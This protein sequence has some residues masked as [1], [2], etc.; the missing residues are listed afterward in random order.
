[1]QEQPAFLLVTDLASVSKE[2]ILDSELGLI[3][4]VMQA[5][6]MYSLSVRL[7]IAFMAELRIQQVTC[8][9]YN[10]KLELHLQGAHAICMQLYTWGPIIGNSSTGLVCRTWLLVSS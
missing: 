10:R 6:I 3:R 8:C 5:C 1:M 7:P 9:C 4:Q 2:G